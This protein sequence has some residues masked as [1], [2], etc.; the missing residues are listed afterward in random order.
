MPS[1]EKAPNEVRQMANE[2]LLEVEQHKPVVDAG[3]SVT[4][5]V[6]WPCLDENG[7]PIGMDR[8]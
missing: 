6:A 1:Y 3:V 8:R 2:I 4:Y 5:M 7:S